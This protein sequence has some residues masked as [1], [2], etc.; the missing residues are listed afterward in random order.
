MF[1]KKKKK[2]YKIKLSIFLGVKI[3]DFVELAI[4]TKILWVGFAPQLLLLRGPLLERG[5]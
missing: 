3:I 2:N 5:W 1:Q 4:A